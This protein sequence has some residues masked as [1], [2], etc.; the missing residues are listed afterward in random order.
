MTET[1]SFFGASVTQQKSGYAQILKR[2]FE[3]ELCFIHGFG[4]CHLVD[5]GIYRIL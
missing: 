5:A 4:S 2:Y 3:S 1:I